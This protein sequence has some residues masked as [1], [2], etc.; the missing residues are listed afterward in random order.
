MKSIKS[1]AYLLARLPIGMSFLGHGLVRIPKISA[2][3]EEMANNFADT[4]LPHILVLTFG[5]IHPFV[6][7]IL[8]ILLLGGI[9]MRKSSAFGVIL[10]CILIFG[11]SLIESWSSVSIQMF[12][13]L[14]FVGLFLWADLNEYSLLNH[15]Q[16]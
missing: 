9:A 15:N 13:G 11:S 4:L 12:Y 14:Y 16:L 7:L 5:Y 1:Q 2:F 3:A 8:G 6:E 10:M